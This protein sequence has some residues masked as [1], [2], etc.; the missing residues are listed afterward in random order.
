MVKKITCTEQK[1]KVLREINIKLYA[2]IY[3][4]IKLISPGMSL[5]RLYCHRKQPVIM[6]D[7]VT[8]KMRAT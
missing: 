8:K 2:I 6:I 4:N 7:S 3:Y 5:G 1:K